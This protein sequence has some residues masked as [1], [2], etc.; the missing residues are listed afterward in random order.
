MGCVEGESLAQQELD[1]IETRPGRRGA[2]GGTGHEDLEPC[3]FPAHVPMCF[4]S[5]WPRHESGECLSTPTK[6]YGI[7]D[8]PGCLPRCTH[9]W[10][11]YGE[12][13]V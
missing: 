4:T 6:G 13:D 12:S 8:P 3:S 1:S 5:G 11:R 9:G 2:A 7:R 10:L